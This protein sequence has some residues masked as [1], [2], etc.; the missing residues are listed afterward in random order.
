MR[1]RSPTTIYRFDSEQRGDGFGLL[2]VYERAALYDDMAGALLQQGDHHPGH[3]PRRRV[4]APPAA[5]WP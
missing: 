3:D 4:V 2:G 1:S 5:F